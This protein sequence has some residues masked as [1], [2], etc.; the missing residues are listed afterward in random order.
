MHLEIKRRIYDK[1]NN[2]V[3]WRKDDN[4]FSQNDVNGAIRIAYPHRKR[5]SGP[6]IPY[7]IYK[8]KFQSIADLNIKSKTNNLRRKYKR[9]HQSPWSRQRFTKQNTKSISNQI[10]KLEKL[11]YIKIHAWCQKSPLRK[12]NINQ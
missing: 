12:G 11:N 5:I 1:G 9:M 4:L 10:L 6:P 2:A 8:T 7:S 3:M